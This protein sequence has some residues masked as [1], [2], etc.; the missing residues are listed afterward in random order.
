MKRL[1]A[2]LLLAVMPG[3]ALAYTFDSGWVAYKKGDYEAAFAAWLALAE[4]GDAQSQ[5]ALG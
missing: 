5:T 2:I 1:L 3:I 4:T